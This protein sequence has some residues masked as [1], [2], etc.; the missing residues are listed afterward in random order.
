M[1]FYKFEISY[2]GSEYFG[3]QK[4]PDQ[5][6]I[7][8]ELEES[9]CKIFKVAEIKTI[10]SGR[11]DTG[12]HALSQI[13]KV[14]APFEIPCNNLLLAVNSMLSLSIR[15]K[16]IEFCDEAF[17][18]I[19]MAQKKEY[20]YLFSVGKNN[21]QQ[22][23]FLHRN[24]VYLKQ[25]YALEDLQKAAQVFVGKHNFKNYQNVGTE[26]SS[27]VRTIFDCTI[28]PVKKSVFLYD[29]PQDYYELIIVGNGFLKQM[30]R[31]IMGTIWNCAEGKISCDDIRK[32]L[33]GE[34]EVRLAPVAPPNG[35]F[36]Y[37][38]SY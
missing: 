19:F 6:T 34:E 18:P 5:K 17:H 7:Q 35:L 31:S 23:S 27:T 9:L 11:T 29:E 8:G 33:T 22:S 25:S 14:E 30:V 20:R 28:A 15:I 32:S 4:Q 24:C 26:V 36:L 12:V 21:Y 3:W 10:G 13:V 16:S 2:D 37:K 38:V 1:I